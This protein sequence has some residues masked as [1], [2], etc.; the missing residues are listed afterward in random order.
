[1]EG[2]ETQEVTLE[3]KSKWF[4]QLISENPQI[5]DLRER[6]L[7]WTGGYSFSDVIFTDSVTVLEHVNRFN[8]L[9]LIY[10][11]LIA[12]GMHRTANVLRNE[13]GHNFQIID[14]PWDKTDLS[15]LVSLGVLPRE[16]PWGI[17]PE[18]HL[19]FIEENLEEDFFAS[20]YK[21]DPSQI[22]V[23]LLDPTI[24]STFS[25]EPY[26]FKNLKTATLRRIVVLLVTSDVLDVSDDE[27]HR[28]F[29]SIH[30]ITSSSHFLEHLIALFDCHLLKPTDKEQK[31]KILIM[32]SSVR[33][34]VVNLIRK[35][36][37]FHG[38]FIGNK[39]LKAIG[40]LMKR[41]VDNPSKYSSVERFAKTVLASLPTLHYGTKQGLL[42]PPT[43]EPRIQNS[44]VIFKPTLKM[45]DLD[46]LEV[47]RQISILFHNAFK[48]IHSR[49]F[50]VALSEKKASH[51]TP[52][53]VEFLDFGKR[54]IDLTMETV[55]TANDTT[56]AV[57][58][59]TDIANHLND[60]GN[61]DAT[62][63][64]ITAITH[65]QLSHLAVL[66]SPQIIKKIN[67]LTKS[68]GA[69]GE[70]KEYIQ[71]V[72][73]RFEQWLPCV[74][75]MQA[76]L[77]LMPV[78]DSPSMIDGLIN[79]EKRIPISNRVSILYRFQNT[80]YNFWTIPQ[81]QTMLLKGSKVSNAQN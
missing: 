64:I 19:Q 8:I 28:F 58:I 50:F 24:N 4:N 44:Q 37:N 33:V 21:E 54:L 26:I 3:E 17:P 69:G 2:N 16:D 13:S 38:L 30:S 79:W 35:W 1:M 39:T 61:F 70:Y 67:K 48:A 11:H 76:E 65:P 80:A 29:L 41:I 57:N 66:Q 18:T 23:E 5:L 12:I 40:E 31:E 51:Q 36:T 81:I 14:Q 55:L 34:R 22:W 42:G 53:L 56:S 60:L 46:P 27:L 25:S 78:D 32:Q 71:I 52:T 63:C 62:N 45:I 10:Q 77:N 49:E 72:S 68:C 75:N 7:P 73:T 47:A 74:P 6:V 59:I 43:C 20:S 9:E 15:I